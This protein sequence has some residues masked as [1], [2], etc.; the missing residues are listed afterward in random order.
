MASAK[1]YRFLGLALQTPIWDYDVSPTA[2]SQATPILNRVI[3]YQGYFNSATPGTVPSKWSPV[4]TTGFKG[5]IDVYLGDDDWLG[6]VEFNPL[7]NV[8]FVLWETIAGDDRTAP[9]VLHGRRGWFDTG[10][11]TGSFKKIYPLLGLTQLTPTYSDDMPSRYGDLNYEY[12]FSYSD[13]LTETFVLPEFIWCLNTAPYV[14][15][16]TEDPIT[17]SHTST[18]EGQQIFADVDSIRETLTFTD[19]DYIQRTQ[20]AT[21]TNFTHEF[22]DFLQSKLV[23]TLEY[24]VDGVF[25]PD[26][27]YPNVIRQNQILDNYFIDYMIKDPGVYDINIYRDRDFKLKLKTDT[28]DFWTFKARIKENFKSDTVLAEFDIEINDEEEYLELSLDADTTRAL[29]DDITIDAG[30]VSSVKTLVWDLKIVTPIYKTY[31]LIYGNCYVNRT[32]T[33]ST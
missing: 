17:M 6:D 32:V 22:N 15:A 20:S 21:T 5:E 16:Y 13:V 11:L 8:I 4:Y 10:Y 19:G 30:S 7:S 23:R 12:N 25:Y 31:S 24:E 1:T 14:C 33:R 27:L 3:H 18:A 9:E 28:V 29:I 26:T 2:I